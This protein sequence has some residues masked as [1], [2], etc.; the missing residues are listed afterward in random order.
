MQTLRVSAA[1]LG[2]VYG[3]MRLSYL[4]ASSHFGSPSYAA[5]CTRLNKLRGGRARQPQ[6]RKPRSTT[7]EAGARVLE[8]WRG[9]RGR[10]RMP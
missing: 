9:E 7:E 6:P 3:S 4:K 5:Q 2:L 10:E 1:G 8:C